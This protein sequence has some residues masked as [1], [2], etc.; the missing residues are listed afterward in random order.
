MK[1][2][3]IMKYKELTNL[4][5]ELC[6]SN[7]Y[8]LSVYNF[9]GGLKENNKIKN[10]Y[11][12]LVI[13]NIREIS[14]FKSNTSKKIKKVYG[15]NIPFRKSIKDKKTK[16][17]YI[18]I[19]EYKNIKYF[20]KKEWP[21]VINYIIKNN[22][23]IYGKKLKLNEIKIKDKNQIILPLKKALKVVFAQKDNKLKEDFKNY[24]DKIIPKLI[25]WYPK[26]RKEIHQFYNS[27]DN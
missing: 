16:S 1:L 26:F 27:I 7:K 3:L 2:S 25:K 22:Y 17:I 4:I 9:G 23:L 20:L 10:D 24:L 11:D 21:T 15:F 5:K 12:L 8:N 13:G 19:L 18:H 14:R 6:K